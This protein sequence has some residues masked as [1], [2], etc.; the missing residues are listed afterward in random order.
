MKTLW[1]TWG[2]H[3]RTREIARALNIRLVE[4]LPGSVPLV[5]YVPLI[6]R[7]VVQ[8]LLV[9]P[10]QLFVQC[11]SVVLGLLA[12]ALKK[13]FGY[14]LVADLH[15]EAVDPFINRSRLY[16][17]VIRLI[18]E[19]AD[20]SIVSNASLSGI[21][22]QSGGRAFVL[23][24]GIPALSPAEPG[25]ARTPSGVVFVCTFAP[26]EPFREVLEAARALEGTATVYV[27][28][29]AP[30]ELHGPLAPNVTLT[31]YLPDAEYEK[32]LR[33]ADVIVD[34]TAMENC[35]VCGGY[36]AVALGK[37]LVTSDTTALRE[38]FRRGTI[39]T[40]HD[41]RSIADAIGRA[42][43]RRQVLAAEMLTLRPELESEW[44][45]TAARLRSVLSPPT[46][47]CS[48]RGTADSASGR[49]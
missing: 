46:C 27:T 3:R 1:I 6:V 38:H 29:R 10:T 5:R 45:I 20:L 49:S 14:E 24:D 11:P 22:E 43:E 16:G 42:L 35:L 30:R 32:L 36:E 41:P 48:V 12:V 21:V 37:P 8:L 7:T 44:A 23:P 9:R 25:R 17:R 34:L 26:D 28:G 33:D 39:F 13:P 4:L 15:N 18:H 40:R 31:G 19:H 47:D 2:H